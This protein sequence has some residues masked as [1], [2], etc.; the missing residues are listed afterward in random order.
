MVL[1]SSCP[2]IIFLKVPHLGC[3]Q[4]VIFKACRSTFSKFLRC[5][6]LSKNHCLPSTRRSLNSSA[7]LFNSAFAKALS[8]AGPVACDLFN[9]HHS[10]RMSYAVSAQSTVLPTVWRLEMKSIPIPSSRRKTAKALHLLWSQ[11]FRE[12]SHR[13]VSVLF[14]R[15]GAE[16]APLWPKRRQVIQIIVIISI[17]AR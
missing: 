4:K 2:W 11:I 3:A 17:D 15:N 1:D 10:L 12:I 14:K 6:A 13:M 16:R 9:E 8:N 7:T 5:L